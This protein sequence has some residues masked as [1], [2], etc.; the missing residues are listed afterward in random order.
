MNSKRVEQ[1][2]ELMCDKGCKALWSDIAAL[3]EGDVVQE[4]SALSVSERAQVLHELKTIMAVYEG[5][6][7]PEAT[8]N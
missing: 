5:S 2:V 3:E 6:C 7:E 8:D 4:T 1:C